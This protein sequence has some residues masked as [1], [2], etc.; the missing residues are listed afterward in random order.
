MVKPLAAGAHTL[1]ILGQCRSLAHSPLT[2]LHHPQAGNLTNH[3]MTIEC[4]TAKANSALAT[5]DKVSQACERFHGHGGLMLACSSCL[6][7]F[8]PSS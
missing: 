4:I 3:K 1:S 2:S 5:V 7:W 8:S 6:W